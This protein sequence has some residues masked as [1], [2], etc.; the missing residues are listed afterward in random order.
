MVLNLLFNVGRSGE[1]KEAAIFAES[2]TVGVTPDYDVP[3]GVG[4]DNVAGSVDTDDQGSIIAREY[5]VRH[6]REHRTPEDVLDAEHG[7]RHGHESTPRQP[8]PE[9]PRQSPPER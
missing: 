9:L 8:G 1:D 6:V 2:P 5:D 4:R 3:G 7:H